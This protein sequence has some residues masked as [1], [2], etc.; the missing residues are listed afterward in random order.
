M[1]E[2][3]DLRVLENACAILGRENSPL[4]AYMP[5]FDDLNTIVIKSSADESFRKRLA[6]DRALWKAVG[7]CFSA[8]NDV[9][10]RNCVAPD[11]HLRLLRGIVLLSRNFGAERQDIPQELLLQ[12]KLTRWLAKQQKSYKAM[13]IALFSVSYEFFYNISKSSV[14]FDKSSLDELCDILV[15]PA[16]VPS[17]NRD[18]LLLPMLCFMSHLVQNDD[19]LYYFLK[20]PCATN[21]LSSL[22]IEDIVKSHIEVP[23]VQGEKGALTS[24]SA[25]EAVQVEIWSS[26]LTHES[27]GVYLKDQRLNNWENFCTILSLS[28]LIITS[29]EKWDKTQLT[30]IMSWVYEVFVSAAEELR[31]FFEGDAQDEILAQKIHRIL[32][33]SLDIISVLSKFE[34]VREFILYY[35]GLKT[36]VDLLSCLQKNCIR[37]NITRDKLGVKRIRST[38]AAGEP[39]KDND[40]KASRI[41]F[42]TG[43]IKATNFPECKSMVIEILA[44]LCYGNE[45][46]QNRCRE[47][48]ALEL[49]LSNCILD[50]N[51]PFIKERSIMCIRFLL[52]G[53]QKNQEFVAKLE[54]KRAIK[55]DVLSEAGFDIEIDESGKIGLKQ[56]SKVNT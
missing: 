41:D 56:S 32:T 43:T 3:V 29:R 52:E 45:E 40:K 13:E 24:I 54:A 21:I 20:H 30:V 12:N 5:I 50:D 2:P 34:H 48:H 8:I 6:G 31:L 25:L 36:L 22:L 38:N 4:D 33:I 53:N 42:E 7:Q 37:I 39:V 14:L 18:T 44:Y 17:K 47:L 51:D 11:L 35:G 15:Y 10:L 27:F 23:V 26:I 9:D 1:T 28:Q 46:I 49:V 55:D 16:T 19:F